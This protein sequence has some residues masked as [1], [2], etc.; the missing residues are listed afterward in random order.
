MVPPSSFSLPGSSV[1]R[2]LRR[3][4]GAHIPLP[5]GGALNRLDT[6]GWEGKV[7]LRTKVVVEE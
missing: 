7:V 4:E 5:R 1:L 3:V 6:R 2:E